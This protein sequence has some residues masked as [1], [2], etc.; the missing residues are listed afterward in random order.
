[1]KW[2]ASDDEVKSQIPETDRSAKVVK[3][4]EIEPQPSSNLGLIWNAETNSLIVCRRTE[5]EVPANITQRIVL[6]LVSAV[7]DPLGICSPFTIRMRFTPQP[8]QTSINQLDRTLRQ[9]P[10]GTSGYCRPF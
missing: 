2:I 10:S 4:F 1:M 3:F 6:S 9:C 5:Q 8:N 7:F